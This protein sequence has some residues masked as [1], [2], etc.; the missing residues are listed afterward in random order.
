MHAIRGLAWSASQ[1]LFFVTSEEGIYTMTAD[2]ESDFLAPR[3]PILAT[4]RGW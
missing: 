4:P 1:S 2:G 3:G